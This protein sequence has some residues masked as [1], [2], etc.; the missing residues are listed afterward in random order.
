MHLSDGTIKK[1]SSV[2]RIVLNDYRTASV[3]QKYGI[4]YCCGSNWPL[5]TVCI[6][7]GI[8]PEQ[9]IEELQKATR[10]LHVPASLPFDQ[11]SLDFL[12]DYIVNI[13]HQYLKQVLPELESLLVHFVDEH[14]KKY[15]ELAEVLFNYRKLQKDILPHLLEEENTFFPYIRQV[16]HAY[17]SND[18][19]AGLL[20]K[21]LRKPIDKMMGNEHEMV[22]GVLYKFRELTNNYTVPQ[23]ACT[24]HRVVFSKLRELDNDL[25]QHIFLE[26][27]ILFP[28]ALS[29]EKDLLKRFE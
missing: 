25:S 22:S 4:G 27:E 21:T 19:Y 15:P 16:A 28:K 2:G 10:H 3:F 14:L 1:E 9:L 18:S 8:V 12:T 23:K 11:W 24:S 7:K 17:E 29:M 26:N 5:E 6:M 13:H 20:V